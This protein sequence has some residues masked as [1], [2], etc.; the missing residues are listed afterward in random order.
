MFA[1]SSAF[2]QT[3]LN[4]DETRALAREAYVFRALAREAYVFG[5]PLPYIEVQIDRSTAVTKPQG[6]PAPLNQFAHFRQ[7]PDTSDRTVVGMNLDVL[8]SI[9]SCNLAD[10]PLVLSLPDITDR[11][12]LMQFLDAWNNVPHVLGTRASNGKGG[13]FA[14]VG[15]SFKGTL[16]AGLTELRMPTDSVLRCPDWTCRRSSRAMSA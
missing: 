8:L 5:F 12:W 14:I 2:A 1:A 4:P 3:T 13:N 9:A 15:P 7:L 16:P 10:E 11:F 6:T